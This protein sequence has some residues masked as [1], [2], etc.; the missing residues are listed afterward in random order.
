MPATAVHAATRIDPWPYWD[1][2]ELFRVQ[3]ACL[4]AIEDRR[5]LAADWLDA[6]PPARAVIFAKIAADTPGPVE[7]STVD[8]VRAKIGEVGYG[9]GPGWLTGR[10]GLTCADCGHTTWEFPPGAAPRFEHRGPCQA[11][12]TAGWHTEAGAVY[13]VRDDVLMHEDVAQMWNRAAETDTDD[14]G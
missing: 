10:R 3:D 11:P 8:T 5:P 14:G 6:L 4:L 12:A 1:T 9:A 2:E 13:V 7:Q